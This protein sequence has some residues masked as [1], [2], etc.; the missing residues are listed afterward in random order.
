MPLTLYWIVQHEDGFRYIEETKVQLISGKEIHGHRGVLFWKKHYIFKSKVEIAPFLF[1]LDKNTMFLR[2]LEVGDDK[3]LIP[4][5]END[6]L[7]AIIE[8][9]TRIP[10]RTKKFYQNTIN[11]LIK[12]E[13]EELLSLTNYVL[14]MRDELTHLVRMVVDATDNQY[15]ALFTHLGIEI[16]ESDVSRLKERVRNKLLVDFQ[17][18]INKLKIKAEQLSTRDVSRR[19]NIEGFGVNDDDGDLAPRRRARRQNRRDVIADEDLFS[20]LPQN[21]MT[22]VDVT[23]SVALPPPSASPESSQSGATDDV[24]SVRSL[25]NIGQEEMNSFMQQLENGTI[26]F[27]DK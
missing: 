26:E 1:R 10:N 5:Q 11:M 7:E 15:K 13:E 3:E 22:P 6:D 24:E 12:R 19:L 27:E 9:A 14:Q 2:M 21:T 8:K 20:A 25:R 4:L 23:N 17:D 18:E 16:K